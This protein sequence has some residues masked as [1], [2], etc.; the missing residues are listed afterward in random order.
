MVDGELVTLRLKVA[1]P[2][3]VVPVMAPGTAPVQLPVS[4]Q[5]VPLAP[6][7]ALGGGGS[8]V[9]TSTPIRALIASPMMA[10]A[11]ELNRRKSLTAV[12]SVDSGG[13]P[14]PTAVIS[15]VVKLNWA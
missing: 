13:S 14:V 1:V 7:Q 12:N 11:V 15:A 5:L 6:V 10:G 9:M 2:V 4:L 8:A 3:F